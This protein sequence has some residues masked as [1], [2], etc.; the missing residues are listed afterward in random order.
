MCSRMCIGVYGS[1]LLKN[2]CIY[3]FKLY[4]QSCE[5]FG[6]IEIVRKTHVLSELK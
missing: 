6:V 5:R 3:V 2:D 4:F 1:I